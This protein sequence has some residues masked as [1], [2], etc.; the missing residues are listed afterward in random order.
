M[1]TGIDVN[2]T[3][4][5]IS[6]YDKS[7]PK[8]VWKIGLLRRK[9]YVRISKIEA[10]KILDAAIDA[11]KNGLKSVEN[12]SSTFELKDGVVPDEFIETIP[13]VLLTELGTTIL[14]NS[15]LSVGE[16]KN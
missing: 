12:Y 5:F 10:D 2:Q 7:E 13:L 1:I 14:N 16:I 4:D 15:T 3:V 9:D 6:Q 11:V 8:T